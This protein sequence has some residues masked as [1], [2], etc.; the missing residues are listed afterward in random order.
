MRLS[1]AG[2]AAVLLTL[3][4]GA[5]GCD[6]VSSLTPFGI[7]HKDYGGESENRNGTWKGK[8]A[9]GGEV[10]FQVGSDKVSEL[11]LHHVSAGCNL[12]FDILDFAPPV[13]DG[14]FTIDMPAEIQGRIVITGNFT[15][16]STCSGTYLFEGFQAGA[17]P[18]AGSG[19]FFA[20][21][22]F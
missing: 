10:T 18:S 1:G 12:A 5:A 7:G 4:L 19:T 13:I 14:V 15:T 9:T 21:K 8:T 3:V 2:A 16:A 17:C 6:L 20:E 11:L 22:T